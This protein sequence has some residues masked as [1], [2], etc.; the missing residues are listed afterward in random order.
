MPIAIVLHSVVALG[1]GIEAVAHLF[2]LR[3]EWKE[4]KGNR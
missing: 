1:A 3:R 4:N 2:T